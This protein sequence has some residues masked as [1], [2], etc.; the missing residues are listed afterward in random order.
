MIQEI[1]S[2]GLF[3]AEIFGYEP[4][5]PWQRNFYWPDVVTFEYPMYDPIYNWT[6]GTIANV[7]AHVTYSIEHVSEYDENKG[8]E[9]LKTYL[10]YT[11]HFNLRDN[12]N[13]NLRDKYGFIYPGN[14]LFHFIF[15]L[16]A[17]GQAFDAYGAFDIEGRI[18][19]YN[20][21]DT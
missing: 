13:F 1:E 14:I 5:K 15:K 12:F 11:A 20:C 3:E 8:Y 17:A 6:L 16:L 21:D 4:Y 2:S 10:F 9:V 19:L 7:T 18:F